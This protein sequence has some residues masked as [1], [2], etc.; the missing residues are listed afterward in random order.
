MNEIIMDNMDLQHL[1]NQPGSSQADWEQMWAP[2]DPAT[3]TEALAYLRSDDLVL[4]IGAGDLR[5]ARLAAALAR[6][7]IAV[8]RQ[9]HIVQA[10]LA[11]GG[12]LP[13]NLAVRIAD[14]LTFPIPEGVSCAALLMRHCT[15]FREYA[16]RLREAGCERLVTNARWGMGVECVDLLAD[17]LN[18]AAVPPGWYSCWCGKV[19]FKPGVVEEIAEAVLERVNEVTGCP[20]CL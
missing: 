5:F 17:R 12:P 11:A 9:A 4:D 13:A 14:A 19:G 7:V 2:Y 1:E 20:E 3:Y 15:H 10:G 8:E 18:Y 16:E 6:Q